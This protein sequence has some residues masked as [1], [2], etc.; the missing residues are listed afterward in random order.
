[1][2]QP[3]LKLS[4][5]R[6]YFAHTSLSALLFMH[7]TTVHA[8]TLSRSAVSLKALS[9]S[10]PT[11]NPLSYVYRAQ[12][13]DTAESVAFEFL[14]DARNKA[15]L[16]RFYLHNKIAPNAVHSALAEGVPLNIPV[17]WMFL[18]PVR[19]AVLSSTGNIQMSHTNT[20]GK[21]IQISSI[22]KAIEEGTTI[23]TAAN[24]FVKIKFPDHS[25]LSVGPNSELQIETLKRYASSDIF[26][27]QVHLSQ[28]R[29]ES[30]VKP[31]TSAASDYTVKS[32]RLTTGVRGTIFSV[33]DDPKGNAVAEVLEGGVQLTDATLRQLAIPVG[34]GSVVQQTEASGLV[35]LL[36]APNW[37]CDVA[38]G[39]P[40]VQPLPVLAPLKT[41]R[42]RLDVY[43]GQITDVQ[44]RNPVAQ[45]VQPTAS[46]PADLALGAYT[47]EVKAIDTNGLQGYASLKALQVKAVV[48]PASDGWVYNP[49]SH[50]WVQ[51]L[52]TP[53]SSSKQV[54][55]N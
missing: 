22:D 47:V 12:A 34:F 8:Q 50:T 45:Y 16:A 44:G 39:T 20:Q 35:A 42:M 33:G 13:G 54:F 53:A 29:V 7:L 18:K 9:Q 46:L 4:M 52:S 51:T 10:K 11:S 19:A 23:K 48:V 6:A 37:L 28:G 27:I 15:N 40:L 5:L 26:K 21:P 41:H 1:M 3:L 43:A 14:D 36:P 17:A 32:K 31:L 24:S 38:V 25:V 30:T 55:C 2:N 49:T